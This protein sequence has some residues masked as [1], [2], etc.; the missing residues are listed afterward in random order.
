MKL[1]TCEESGIKYVHSHKKWWR[2]SFEKVD[3]TRFVRG[4][5]PVTSWY[6]YELLVHM[7]LI[8]SRWTFQYQKWW[9]RASMMIERIVISHW[10]RLWVSSTRWMYTVPKRMIPVGISKREDS[11]SAR[12]STHVQC[13]GK[14]MTRYDVSLLLHW[15]HDPKLPTN[16]RCRW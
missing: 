9:R 12:R 6:L 7:I 2:S 11:E 14:V 5:C 8:G 16:M 10:V 13:D 3:W 15:I 1:Y 4:L